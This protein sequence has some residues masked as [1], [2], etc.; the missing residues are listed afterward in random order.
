METLNWW[1]LDSHKSSKR[2]PWLNSTISELDGKTKEMLK[3]IEEEANSFA[4]RAEMY[5]KKRP[6]L[7]SMVKDLYQAHRSLA[8]RYDLLKSET[9]PRLLTPGSPFSPKFYSERRAYTLDHTSDC[10]SDI[11]DTE[12]EVEDPEQYERTQVNTETKQIKNRIDKVRGE[13]VDSKEEDGT[14]L[15]EETEEFCSEEVMKLRDELEKLIKENKKA[16]SNAEALKLMLEVEKL[17]EENKVQT[18]KLKE[19]DEEKKKILSE[20][21]NGEV[22]KLRV[23]LERLMEEIETQKSRLMDQENEKKNSSV[24]LCNEILNLRE[25]IEKLKEEDQ[26]QK[27]ELVQKD[28][29]KREVIRQLSFAIEV[30]KDQNTDMKKRITRNM[31][32]KWN[33]FDFNATFIARLLNRSQKSRAA[34]VGP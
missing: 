18:A 27:A 32:K 3:L 29:E 17:K 13:G 5:Y 24:D 4:E 19:K 12:S 15:D 7:I 21:C 31:S 26:I 10:C 11:F 14:I 34:I 16:L 22:M 33:P 30:L 6:E 1:W 9:G 28:E 23:E 25:Q 20:L 2:S 8:E